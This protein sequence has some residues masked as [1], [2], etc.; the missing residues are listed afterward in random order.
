[1]PNRCYFTEDSLLLRD[2]IVP[3]E[4]RPLSALVARLEHNLNLQEKHDDHL[5]KEPFKWMTELATL[6]TFAALPTLDESRTS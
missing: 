4:Q 1:M 2:A 3:C 5:A 6:Q